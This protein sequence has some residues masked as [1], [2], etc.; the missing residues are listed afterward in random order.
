[1]HMPQGLPRR[2]RVVPYV[3]TWIEILYPEVLRSATP[4]VPYVGTWIEIQQLGL[5][6][7]LSCRRSLRGNVDRN[8]LPLILRWLGGILVVPYVGTWIEIFSPQPVR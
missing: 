6:H 5:G 1:M 3:G 2:V 4:V 8:R 7:R